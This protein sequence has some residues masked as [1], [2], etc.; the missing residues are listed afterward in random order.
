MRHQQNIKHKDIRKLRAENVGRY[1]LC[2]I[3]DSFVPLFPWEC[4]AFLI[5]MPNIGVYEDLK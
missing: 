2:S 5:V 1:V 4:R 3:L